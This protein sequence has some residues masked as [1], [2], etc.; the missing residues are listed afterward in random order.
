MNIAKQK[1]NALLIFIYL[2]IIN[3]NITLL[4]SKPKLHYHKALTERKKI[5]NEMQI[6]RKII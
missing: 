5:I 3:N 6:K 4:L 1:H 2:Y